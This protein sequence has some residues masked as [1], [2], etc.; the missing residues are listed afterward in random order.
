MNG[1]ISVSRRKA[2]WESEHGKLAQLLYSDH[3]QGRAA[4][5]EAKHSRGMASEVNPTS[6]VPTNVQT[7]WALAWRGFL[8]TVTTDT[9]SPERPQAGTTWWGLGE[10]IPWVPQIF[11]T[12]WRDWSCPAGAWWRRAL[13]KQWCPEGGG[14]PGCWAHCY[15]AKGCWATHEALGTSYPRLWLPEMFSP[16]LRPQ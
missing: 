4:E 11:G 6:R 15:R 3:D 12:C 8:V 5:F 1:E 7:E 9:G 13:H 16:L 2:N 14:R 10:E